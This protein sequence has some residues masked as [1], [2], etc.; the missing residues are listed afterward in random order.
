M[1][2]GPFY[3][4]IDPFYNVPKNG[5]LHVLPQYLEAYQT[6][7]PWNEFTNIV[8]DLK[9]EVA[10][11][12]DVDG[13]GIVDVEDVNAAINI[14]LKLKS[15]NDYPGS[16]DLDGNGIADVED[17]NAIINIILGL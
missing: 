15:M 6:T 9:E 5:T 10:I 14:V 17:V 4:I 16:A 2:D 1:R 7:Y 11:T 12:G 8:G 3:I 13:S